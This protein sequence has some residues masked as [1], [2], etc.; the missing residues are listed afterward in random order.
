MGYGTRAL[1]ILKQYYE[2]KIPNLDEESKSVQEEIEN[3]DED[4]VGLLE[5]HI[6]PKKSLPP[7]LFKLSERPPEKLDY[8]GVSFGL[9]EG[10]LKFWKRAGKKAFEWIA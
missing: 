5:E 6:E 1:D 8:L 10:L 4:E 3:V 7:L 9:T 2:F